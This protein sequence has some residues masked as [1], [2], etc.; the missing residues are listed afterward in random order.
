MPMLFNREL[1]NTLPNKRVQSAVSWTEQISVLAGRGDGENKAG[2]G[3]AC[4][5]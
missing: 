5:V 2:Y 1:I 3:T 4:Q